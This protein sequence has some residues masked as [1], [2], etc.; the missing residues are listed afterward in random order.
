MTEQYDAQT[1]RLAQVQN[2]LT[3]FKAAH[4]GRPARTLEE[5][6]E[7]VGSPAG[8]QLISKSFQ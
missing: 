4:R 2:L 5:L 3:L 1:N 6:E 7:W 8:Q